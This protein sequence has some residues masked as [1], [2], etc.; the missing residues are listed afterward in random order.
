MTPGAQTRDAPG[1]ETAARAHGVHFAGTMFPHNQPLALVFVQFFGGV[2][3]FKTPRRI[4]RN[5]DSA[6][7]PFFA[8][9]PHAHSG[10]LPAT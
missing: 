9:S 3:L 7:R 4:R 10:Y 8:E 1:L 2:L 5:A 6:Q